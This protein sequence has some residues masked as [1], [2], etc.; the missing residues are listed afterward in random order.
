MTR[1]GW[2]VALVLVA[3]CGAPVPPAPVPETPAVPSRAGVS[4][5]LPSA[6]TSRTPRPTTAAEPDC[7]VDWVKSYRSLALL[8]ND[9][10]V[11]VR[12]R[13]VAT[14][15]VQLKAFGAGNS[16]SLRDARRTTFIVEDTLK[17]AVFGEIRILEDVCPN[18]TVVPGEDWLL[19]G[20]RLDD[21]YG[22][23]DGREHYLTLGGPQGQ[24]RIRGGVVSGPFHT[25][26]RAV[27]GYEGA[28]IAE[29]LD[30]LARVPPLDRVGA[31]ATLSDR[32]WVVQGEPI[33]SDFE[34]PSDREAQW[35]PDTFGG[36][37]DAAARGG[38]DLAPYLGRTVQVA[39]F[40]LENAPP[41]TV[42]YQATIVLSDGRP[43]GG[44]IIAGRDSGSQVSQ[45]FALTERGPALAY[46]A[47]L[48]SR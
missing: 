9:A 44:W 41:A 20:S 1:S 47:T 35:W 43:V 29:L 23:G 17:G 11:I 24:F 48:A 3:S 34:L 15:T 18:L 39:Q 16:V 30:D 21:R 13:A 45:V 5:A 14:D 6:A 31:R 19:F 46:G 40:W 33:L 37:I 7:I 22:P 28:S 8:A 36:I 27:H 25:F 38:S 4:S 32:G 12:A 10:A 2:L 26:A 42:L